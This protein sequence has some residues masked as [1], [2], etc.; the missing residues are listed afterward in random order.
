MYVCVMRS[1]PQRVG[2]AAQRVV[3]GRVR[4]AA[5]ALPGR[6]ARGAAAHGARCGAR[7]RHRHQDRRELRLR[8]AQPLLQV[9]FLPSQYSFFFVNSLY[10]ATAKGLAHTAMF[11]V[12]YFFLN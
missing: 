3:G 5:A 1:V 11:S 6:A 8:A 4:A 12:R 9:G 2:R 7:Q 10:I